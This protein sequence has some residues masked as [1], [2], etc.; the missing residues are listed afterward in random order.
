MTGIP[1]IWSS[2]NVHVASI[3][4]NR[5]LVTANGQGNTQI[6]VRGLTLSASIEV[7]VMQQ[8]GELKLEPS[9]A[10][11]TALGDSI[12]VVATAS[13]QNG[14]PIEAAA[15]TWSSSDENVATVSDSGWVIAAGNGTAQ[16][17]AQT[18]DLK[19]TADVS[20]MQAASSVVLETEESWAVVVGDMIQLIAIVFDRNGHPIVDALV[21][22][23][24]NDE[25]VATVSPEGLVTAVEAGSAQVSVRSGDAEAIAVFFVTVEEVDS[26]L[27]ALVALYNA[28]DGPNWSDNTNW[29]SGEPLDTWYGVQAD[30]NGRI[31]SLSLEENQLSG[32]IPPELGRLENMKEMDFQK[33]RLT[34]SIPS[35]MGQLSRLTYLDIQDNNLKGEIPAELGQL[36]KLE[37]LYLAGNLLS[38]EIPAELGQLENLLALNL[39]QN[40]LSGSIPSELGRL[41]RLTFLSLGVNSLTGEIPPELGHLEAIQYL[42]VG[43]NQLS[44]SIPSVLGRLSRL[45]F[46]SLGDNSL[47]GEI[48]PELGQLEAIQYLALPWNELSGEIPPE[49]GQL[50]HLEVMNFRNNELSGE[51][52]ESFSGLTSLRKLDLSYNARLTGGI[53]TGLTGLMLEELRLD[54]TKLCVP[55]NSGLWD[56]LNAI[57][58]THVNTCLEVFVVSSKAIL[59]QSVQDLD[60]RVPLVA[61]KDALLRVFISVPEETPMPPIT[62][63]FFVNGAL[64]YDTNL[65]TGDKVIPPIIDAGDLEATANALIPGSVIQPSLEMVIEIDPEGTHDSPVLFPDRLPA[66]GAIPVAV[67]EMPPMRLT[68]VPLVWTEDPD[69]DLLAE[70][71]SL[72]ADSEYMRP[73]M[74]RLPVHE[75]I[76]S[77]RDPV[78]VSEDPAKSNPML[79]VTRMTRIMDG[80]ESHYLGILYAGGG[81]AY[82]P[83]LDSVAALNG[84]FIGHELGHNFSL[85][86]APCGGPSGLDPNY[87]YPQGNIGVWGFDARYDELVPPFTPDHMSGC[88][89]PDWTSDYNFKKAMAHRLS[90][91]ARRPVVSSYSASGKSLLI[92]GGVDE[93]GELYLKPSF[94]V[95]APLSLP[96]EHGPYRIAAADQHGNTLFDTSFS[97]DEIVCGEGDG[98]AGG[99][100]FAVPL[101]ADWTAGLAHIGLSGP[102]GYVEM[103][104]D[105]GEDSGTSAALLLDES[106]GEVRGY[107][108]DWPE[109]GLSLVSARRTLPEPGLRVLVSTGVP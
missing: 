79:D 60:L 42:M 12:R 35:E 85:G 59:T 92:W 63:R 36:E 78:W 37:H 93:E 7:A 97:M 62:A 104:R 14:H 75:L 64:E 101:R 69:E 33:N 105:S 39:Y 50:E 9:E 109:P 17:I 66:Q 107:L 8:V 70:V 48:P 30:H 32:R 27:Q 91:T 108:R 61:G 45:T 29:L 53:P 73:T 83:G 102:E 87:P 95:D 56:W 23:S 25:T 80:E 11:F 40:R 10:A 49:L 19:E 90:G 103:T 16:L 6:K 89:P 20:V 98:E 72:T 26:E 58:V 65:R 31:W 15:V 1:L 21:E 96:A 82:Q 81:L 18:G 13:D 77:V 51:V 46:L 4:S 44:G 41:S 54:L 100:V 76:V 55:E 74:D 2:G 67:Y 28:T 43:W 5:G 94:V 84:F 71:N 47:T 57:P 99:F 86:H 88:G 3:D 52:P 38:G 106:T 34:G 24:S 22:W 68:V